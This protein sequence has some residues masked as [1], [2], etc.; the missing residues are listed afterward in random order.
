MHRSWLAAL[1]LAAC[2]HAPELATE[3]AGPTP[4]DPG[5]A[6]AWDAQGQHVA[7]AGKGLR[8]RDA[9]TGKEQVL[10]QPSPSGLCWSPDGL[11][12]VAAFPHAAGSTLKILNLNGKVV[13]EATVAGAVRGLVWGRSAGI[14]AAG[15]EVQRF[16][17][18]GHLRTLLHRWPADAEPV[19]TV[20]SETTLMPAVAHHIGTDLVRGQ[21]LALAPLEDEVVY[22]RLVSPP[23]VPPYQEVVLRH[24]ATGTE[25]AVA[26]M[27]LAPGTATFAPDGEEI[28]VCEATCQ[29]V[30]PWSDRRTPVANPGATLQQPAP[31]VAAA[32]PAQAQA[33]RL[34]ELRKLRDQRLITPD[35]YAT[36]KAK[37]LQ[38]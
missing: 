8:I 20:A 27:G 22:S 34:L 14:I 17:F 35:D 18:G 12:L 13:R 10:A 26:Q 30:D 7:F 24:L 1:C 5:A 29:R 37:V 6:F 33:G 23:D 32:V 25:K 21:Q 4:A 31:Q 19:L 9:A 28:V 2:T 16:S 38:R 3:P 15:T 11:Q 36:Q